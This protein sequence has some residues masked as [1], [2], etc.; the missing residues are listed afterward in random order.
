MSPV[1]QTL[2]SSQQALFPPPY[3]LT[4]LT[5]LLCSIIEADITDAALWPL[6]D[7]AWSIKCG[8]TAVKQQSHG[9]LTPEHG[10]RCEESDISAFITSL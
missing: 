3:T 5:P 2:L 7:G 9:E 10:E 8:G 4:T 6:K 1:S